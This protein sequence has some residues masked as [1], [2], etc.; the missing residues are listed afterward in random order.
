[1]SAKD[2]INKRIKDSAESD[3]AKVIEKDPKTTSSDEMNVNKDG[4]GKNVITKYGDKHLDNMG[5]NLYTTMEITK[6]HQHMLDHLIGRIENLEKLGVA[7]HNI[8]G[9]HHEALNQIAQ[10][11]TV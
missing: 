5:A 2:A 7:H 3:E 4:A 1:M 11:K 8:L 10:K 9:T 6:L